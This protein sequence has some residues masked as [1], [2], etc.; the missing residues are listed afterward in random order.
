MATQTPTISC[1]I[2]DNINPLSPNGFNFTIQKLPAVSYFCQQVNLPGLTFGDPM[3]AN[4]FASVP[5]PGDHITYDTLNV[6]FLIDQNMNNYQAI[7]NWI[8][9]LG[10]PQSYEQYVKFV[11]EDQ[12]GLLNELAKNYSDATLAILGPNNLPVQTVQFVDVFPISLDS[13]MFQS[14]N[15]DVPYIVGNA[16][17]RYSYYKFI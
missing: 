6:Q 15:Q 12:S 17:F 8:I 14:T 7:F 4:P 11:G 16:T 10:F 3:F 13:I 1:P 2:P 9:A 5:V